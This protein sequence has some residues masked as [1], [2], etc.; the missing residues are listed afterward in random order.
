MTQPPPK[1]TW[2]ALI[3]FGFRTGLLS[4]KLVEQPK[5]PRPINTGSTKPK[6]LDQQWAEAKAHDAATAAA[7]KVLGV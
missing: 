2:P 6:S 1:S 4:L 7:R 5:A 3:A